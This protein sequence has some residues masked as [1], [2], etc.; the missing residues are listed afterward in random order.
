MNPDQHS[1]LFYLFVFPIIICKLKFWFG[2]CCFNTHPDPIVYKLLK[3]SCCP[4]I[5]KGLVRQRAS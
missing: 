2:T 5:V 4:F 1:F 3:A